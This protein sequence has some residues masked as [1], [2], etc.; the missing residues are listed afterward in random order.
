ML[1]RA[2]DRS[3]VLVD[4]LGTGTAPEEGAALAVA[5]L[6]EFR[7]RGCL[8]LATTHHD[9]LKTYASTTP[10]VAQRRRG[11][12]RSAICAHLSPARRRPGRFQRHRYRAAAGPARRT[13]ST[14][15]ARRLSPE[16]HEAAGLIAYLHRSR[17]ESEEI[18]RRAREELAQLEADRR[19]LQTEWVERQNKR[20]AISKRISQTQ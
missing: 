10:G 17:D 18:A 19:E 6:D 9:R 8:T 16:A 20:I 1:E 3:L 13:S 15:R 14:G 4:E 12:R 7:E 5:L 11:I 2:T